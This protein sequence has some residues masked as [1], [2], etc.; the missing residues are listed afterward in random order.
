MFLSD[1]SRGVREAIKLPSSIGGVRMMITIKCPKCETDN[2]YDAEFC[3]HCG[4]RLAKDCPSCGASNP[5]QFTYCTQCGQSLLSPPVTPIPVTPTLETKEESTITP[6]ETK[7]EAPEEIKEEPKAEETRDEIKEEVQVASEE[8]AEAP[9]PEDQII[10]E[11]IEEAPKAEVKEE[12]REEIKI[13]VVMPDRVLTGISGLDPLIGGGFLAGKVYLV[14]GESGTGK[15]VFGMQFLYQGLVLGE[16]GIYI[17]AENKPAHLIVDAESLG[18]DFRKYV[19]ERK[20]GLMDI[21]HHFA[22][23]R[24][25]RA[26]VDVGAV[27][28]D[29]TRQ[30]REFNAQRIVIDTIAPLVFG[31]ENSPSMPEY[32]RHLVAA[33]EDNLGCTVVI[34]SG[35]PAGFA[36]LSRYGIEEF[37]VEG[38][39]VLGMASFNGYC[40]R[41]LSIRKMRSTF[42]DL[43]NHFFEILPHRGMVIRG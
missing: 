16:S 11:E 37:V 28:A 8:A 9:K 7:Q 34:T 10:P 26:T 38:V 2:L 30:V 15:T 4:L 31:Q 40:F 21:S 36:A 32:I 39:I 24:A 5:H 43:N 27:V 13:D 35:I 41:T 23:M 19:R 29:L 18:W 14:S 12:T 25:G 33:I 6:E 17:S 20:L 1:L 42:S 3:R 22:E